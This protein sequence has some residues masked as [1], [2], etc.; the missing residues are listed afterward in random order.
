MPQPVL[1]V[2]GSTP[3]TPGNARS[4]SGVMRAV[5][6]LLVAAEQLTVLITAT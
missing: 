4:T 5:M 3:S 6:Y 1:C 2:R